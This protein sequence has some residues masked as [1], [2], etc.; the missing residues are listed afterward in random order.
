MAIRG[1]ESQGRCLPA[2]PLVPHVCISYKDVQ[3]HA[4]GS[5]CPST[6]ETRYRLV[7]RSGNEGSHSESQ[8]VNEALLERLRAAEEEVC[9][10]VS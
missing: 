3:M 4:N 2:R 9:V 1:C 5:L 8:E 6:I 7:C 10:S